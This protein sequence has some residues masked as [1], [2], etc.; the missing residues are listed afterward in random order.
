MWAGPPAKYKPR[1]KLRVCYARTNPVSFQ[2]QQF[3]LYPEELFPKSFF[4]GAAEGGGPAALSSRLTG[5]AIGP[6]NGRRYRAA[7]RTAL[8]RRL[9]G[10]AIAPLNGRRCRAVRSHLS[11][12]VTADG[13]YLSPEATGHTYQ[14]WRQVIGRVMLWRIWVL[15][16]KAFWD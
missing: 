14:L 1:D 8:S 16:F 5:G 4:G 10:G 3:A 7:W 9:K 6:L 11:P 12:K 2:L 15:H 13:S